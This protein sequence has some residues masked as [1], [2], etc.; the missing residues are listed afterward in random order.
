VRA[1]ADYIN[2][3]TFGKGIN[4]HSPE[5]TAAITP[6]SLKEV[7][8]VHNNKAAILMEIGQLGGVSGDVFVK[9]AFEEPFVDPAGIPQSGKIRILP[10]NPAFC[11]PTDSTEILTRRGWLTH[12]Q[13]TTDDQ[14]LSLDPATNEQ[15]WADVEG[16]NVFD[17]DGP[18]HRFQNERFTS[19]T[20]PD[21]RWV[22]DTKRG[23]RVIRTSAEI[24]NTT[25]SG[26]IVLSGGAQ[27]HF[28]TDAKYT[29]EFVELVGWVVTEG[30]LEDSSG[31]FNLTQ[32]RGVHPDFCDRIDRLAHHYRQQGFM[33]W[34]KQYEGRAMMWRFPAS[35]G[36]EVRA[37]LGERKAM[38]PEFLTSLTFAQANL[39]YHTLL[40]GDGDTQ[41]ARGDFFWQN[42]WEVMDSFQ[43]LAMMLGKHSQAK[44]ADRDY[45]RYVKPSGNVTVYANHAVWQKDMQQTVE[46]YTGKVWC[47]TT[48]TGTWVVRSK[49]VMDGGSSGRKICYLTGNCFP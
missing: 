22:F 47:P 48:S 11:M 14:V 18:M 8:E 12:D 36:H 9:V 3:F 16:I 49:E 7:W 44:L 32:D 24:A 2:N 13:L 20:T 1:F 41:R 37:V 21:H 19:L 26:S 27:T 4:F 30:H 33:V 10:L 35:I 46:H 15:V 29:D 43:M 31:G 28:P 40:D 6:Y 42:N 38:L 34:E 45:G 17:W 25:A 5:A 23:N 39:L